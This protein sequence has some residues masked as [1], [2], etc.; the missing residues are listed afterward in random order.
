MYPNPSTTTA[1][2]EIVKEDVTAFNYDVFDISGKLIEKGVAEGK[3][4]QLSLPQGMYIVKV[5]TN[6]LWESKKLI[7]Y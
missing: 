7:M 1:T 6:E 5:K 2:I 3:I 4:K